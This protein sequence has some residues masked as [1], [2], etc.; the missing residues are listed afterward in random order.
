MR[1][2]LIFT[3]VDGVLTTGQKS[4]HVDESG[5]LANTKI[6]CDRDTVPIL[7]LRDRLIWISHDKKV[8][9]DIAKYRG[10][11]FEWVPEGE[12][13]LD[14]INE[15]AKGV[16][17]VYIGDSLQDLR[18]LQAAWHA[19]VPANASLMLTYALDHSSGSYKQLNTNGGEGVLEEVLLDLHR[20]QEVNLNTLIKN[21]YGFYI[22]NRIDYEDK[23]QD[24]K[25]QAPGD[26]S[27]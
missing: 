9:Q 16:P 26:L 21:K 17:F 4:W 3:D 27:F 2:L 25:D 19:Y 13:K 20:R 24:Q 1:D 11:R 14:K 5:N 23:V 15:I 18:C 8:N 10:V 6:Y 12:C 7:L 22:D